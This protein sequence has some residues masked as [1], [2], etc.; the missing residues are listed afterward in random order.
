MVLIPVIGALTLAIVQ[1]YARGVSVVMALSAAFLLFKL[2]RRI[3]IGWVLPAI[4]LAALVLLPLVPEAYWNRMT[5]MVTQYDIDPTINRRV[6]SYRIGLQLFEQHLLL[7]LGPGNFMAQYM[8]PE[9]RFDRSGVPSVCFNL[10]LSIATQAGLLGLTAFGLILWSAFRN[11]RFVARSYGE[12]DGFLKQ[13]VEVLE[14]VL[15]ALLLVS[16]FEPTDLQKYLWIVLGTAA[17][18][19]RIRRAQ[20]EVPSA[21]PAEA[22]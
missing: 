8:S 6:D 1:T 17:A 13:A 14:I 7:G 4:L 2:R 19:G 5:T 22:G 20:L 15:V 11:L 21:M 16:L 3:L 9:F 18:A 12:A 10:Y